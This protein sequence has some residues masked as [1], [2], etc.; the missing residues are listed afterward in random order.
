MKFSKSMVELF[1]KNDSPDGRRLGQRFYDFFRLH[2]VQDP[3]NK[4]W[5]D[6]LY[7]APSTAQVRRMIHN[8]TDTE[9]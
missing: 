9:N 8:S 6:K 1:F 2:N 3:K 5:A 4:A 7:N